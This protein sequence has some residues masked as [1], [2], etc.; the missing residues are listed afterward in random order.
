MIKPQLTLLPTIKAHDGNNIIYDESHIYDY[1]NRDGDSN[2]MTNILSLPQEEK[3]EYFE[4]LYRYQHLIK[5]I[6]T[7]DVVNRFMGPA[8]YIDEA[9]EKIKNNTD[10]EDLANN[11]MLI[12]YMEWLNK[13]T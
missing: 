11:P 6:F 8:I 10:T 5:K 1:L 9:I 13:K 2:V 7:E 4:F 12:E 3:E